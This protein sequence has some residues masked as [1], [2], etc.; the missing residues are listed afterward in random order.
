MLEKNLQATP[1]GAT[2]VS[3][4]VTEVFAERIFADGIIAENVSAKQNFRQPEF[5]PLEISPNTTT[6]GF[7]RLVF[8]YIQRILL[9]NNVSNKKLTCV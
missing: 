6:W 8:G 3:F 4:T 2:S 5:S 7:Q 1:W 9:W